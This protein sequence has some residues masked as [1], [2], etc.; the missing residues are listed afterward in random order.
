M[1]K[2]LDFWKGKRVF[3][4][5]HTGFKGSWLSILLKNLGSDVYGYALEPIYQTSLYNE[6][7]LEEKITSTIGNLLDYSS[8]KNSI[9]SCRPD[10]IFHMAAQPLV[11]ESYK[12][13]R[14]TLKT[15][16]LGT[17]NILEAIREVSSIK[18]FVNIT[19]D[20][21]YKNEEIGIPFKESDPLGGKDPYSAS[22][23]CSEIV[24]S[25][26]RESF[27]QNSSCKIATA[28]AGNVIGGGD[29]SDDRLIPDIV[30]SLNNLKNPTIRSPR[31][32]RP[33]Q[34]VLD[35]LFG[36]L[37]L[38]QNLYQDDG[39]DGSWNFGPSEDGFIDVSMMAN[40]FIQYWDFKGSIEH[41]EDS[42]S[43]YESKILKLNINKAY[44][45]LNWQPTL[46]INETIKIT[47]MWYQNFY[48]NNSSA[49]D[50]CLNDIDNFISKFLK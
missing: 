37:S 49:Y 38:A 4:S 7:K 25:S 29:W 19:T 10:I 20:K 8:L 46:D 31:S 47:S 26:Y 11:I 48:I 30:K 40:K 12:N 44:K 21:C 39:Y 18:S 28:R 34:H 2:S 42:S 16:I 13:P 15:N 41:A 23:A 43:P 9:E 27:F 14:E 3:I 35:P 32:I 17:A 6:V 5:G 45:E 22:K 1:Q 24:T 36:Y 50:L 33:W